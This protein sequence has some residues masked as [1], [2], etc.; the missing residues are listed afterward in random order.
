MTLSLAAAQITDQTGTKL[1]RTGTKLDVRN[2]LIKP[3]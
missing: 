3:M 1:D 2:P